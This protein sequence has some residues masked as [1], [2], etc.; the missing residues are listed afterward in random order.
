MI[1]IRQ[2][3]YKP[4]MTEDIIDNGHRTIEGIPIPHAEA[5]AVLSAMSQDELA[6]IEDR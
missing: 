2:C 5:E 4:I 1:R 3:G 6:A